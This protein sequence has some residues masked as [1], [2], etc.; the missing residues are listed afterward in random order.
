[1]ILELKNITKSFQQ[2]DQTIQVLK[3]LNL[4]M[5][6][7][8]TL[9][10]LGAS[11]SGKTTL[12]SLIA[13]LDEPSTGELIVSG[14]HLETM[15]ERELTRFR[16]Q[17]MGIVFQQFHLFPHLTA[18]ENVAM[19]LELSGDANATEKAMSALELVGLKNRSS[20]FPAQLSGGENQ[21]VAIAR[22]FVVEPEILLADEPSGS[23]DSTT[24]D[25]VMNLLFD[26][27]ARK[28]TTMILVTHNEQLAK[29][30][31]RQFRF[32]S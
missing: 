13:G 17:K 9:A 10:I 1:M 15:N 16:S 2:G 28:S 29:R 27:V 22:A 23:L 21:R 12:L 26:L 32:E 14:H 7:G 18:V 5:L 25:Q 4:S 24:G 6:K 3:N 11:G 8:E 19:P 31:A 30:C 20:H